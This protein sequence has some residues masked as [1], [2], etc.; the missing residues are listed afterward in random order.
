MSALRIAKGAQLG[1]CCCDEGMAEDY[2]GK[3]S[4]GFGFI[5]AAEGTALLGRLP[6]GR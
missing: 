6:A 1:R 4:A 3:E 5:G 2:P